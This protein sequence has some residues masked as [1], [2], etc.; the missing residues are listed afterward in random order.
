MAKHFLQMRSNIMDQPKMIDI[1]AERIRISKI[2]KYTHYS[3]TAYL[4]HDEE[5]RVVPDLTDGLGFFEKIKYK[6]SNRSVERH[7]NRYTDFWTEV[8]F[9]YVHI[10]MFDGS[11][12]NVCWDPEIERLIGRTKDAVKEGE[13]IGSYNREP[14]DIEKAQDSLRKYEYLSFVDF[15]ILEKLDRIFQT[16]R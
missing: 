5:L 14:R 11:I 7:H 4:R 12:H 2:K 1:G 13:M 9:D 10:L 3:G 6:R 8:T 16:V 15:N